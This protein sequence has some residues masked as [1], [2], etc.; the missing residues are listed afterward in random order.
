MPVIRP[1]GCRSLDWEVE[2]AA[3]IGR[4]AERV[5]PRAALDAVAGYVVANDIS[6][7]DLFLR[8]DEQPFAMDWIQ[9]KSHATFLPLGPCLVPR[10]FVPNPQDLELS[11]SVSGEL[12]QDSRTTEMVFTVAEQISALSMV[13]PLVPGDVILTG[14]PAGT[15]HETRSYLHDGDEMVA[16]IQGLGE[17]RN[18]VHGHR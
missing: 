6:A 17:L 5:A 2:L 7:R 9:H 13:T 4:R 11:L 3:V 18:R 16:C 15:G 12:R 1:A 10:R 14:T 8:T